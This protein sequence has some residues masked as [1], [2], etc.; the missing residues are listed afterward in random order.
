M[1]AHRSTDTAGDRRLSELGGAV[2]ACIC[3]QL[4]LALSTACL[5]A[6]ATRRCTLGLR[7]G[8]ESTAAC[9]ARLRALPA[10]Q[11]WQAAAASLGY[12]WG[13]PQA[14]RRGLARSVCRQASP[15]CCRLLAPLNIGFPQ[16]RRVVAMRLPRPRPPA[17]WEPLLPAATA[18]SAR[19][20]L[21]QPAAPHDCLLGQSAGLGFA[22]IRLLVVAVPALCGAGD[23]HGGGG[24]APAQADRRRQW[25]R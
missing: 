22:L 18:A 5:P 8:T 4:F 13:T 24:P 21:A 19:S 11:W 7:R 2:R 16:C 23:L 9:R 6:P 25:R 15:P 3:A 14:P 20:C 12:R 10:A 1:K 17:R